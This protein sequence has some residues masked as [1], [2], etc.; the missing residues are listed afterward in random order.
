LNIF[1]LNIYNFKS[2]SHLILA[3]FIIYHFLT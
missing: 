1:E 2:L 3:V